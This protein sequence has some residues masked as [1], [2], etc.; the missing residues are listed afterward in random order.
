[1]TINN[2]K[3]LKGKVK[4]LGEV[5]GIAGNWIGVE[6]FTPQGKNDGSVKGVRYFECAPNYGIF[7]KEGGVTVVEVK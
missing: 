5:K 3:D 7:V 2:E 4:Y 6:L 1:M